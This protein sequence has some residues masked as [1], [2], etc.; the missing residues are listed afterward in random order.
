VITSGRDL[1]AGS[2][3][4]PFLR[5]PF[6]LLEPGALEVPLG[7]ALLQFEEL[8]LALVFLALERS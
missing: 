2:S 3:G 4:L 1:V 6:L 5:L 7:L 8:A